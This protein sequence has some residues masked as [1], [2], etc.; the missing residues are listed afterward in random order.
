MIGIGG[1]AVRER[2]DGDEQLLVQTLRDF[3]VTGSA[4][5][6]CKASLLPDRTATF[7]KETEAEAAARGFSV[8]LLA[9]AGNGVVLSRFT[10][11]AEDSSPERLLS[12]IDW[13]RILTKRLDGYL[14]IE[15][16]D[17]VLKERANVWGHVS[18]AL[19]L[20]KK[21]KETFDPNG[22]LNPGRF[23]GGI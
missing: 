7:C 19:P 22:I 6:R 8:Q 11:T 23:I 20:M 18:G 1:S 14:V 16:I 2:Q 15:G 9:H 17:P 5:L 4:A 21:L 13:L 12:F 3:P 10:N